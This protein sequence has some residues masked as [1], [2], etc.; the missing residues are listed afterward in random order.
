MNCIHHVIPHSNIFTQQINTADLHDIRDSI[1]EPQDVFSHQLR[2]MPFVLQ[3]SENV[4]DDDKL[5]NTSTAIK[6]QH[7]NPK[8]LVRS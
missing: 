4:Y 8:S 7:L 2:P 5:T 3:L 1:P 6:I